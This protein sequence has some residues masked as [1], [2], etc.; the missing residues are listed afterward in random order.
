MLCF[1]LKRYSESQ[2]FTTPK[3]SPRLKSLSASTSI[4]KKFV[5]SLASRMLKSVK[6]NHICQKQIRLINK[7]PEF[8]EVAKIVK[9]FKNPKNPKSFPHSSLPTP[10]TSIPSSL[11]QKR[12]STELLKITHTHSLSSTHSPSSTQ[13]KIPLPTLRRPFQKPSRFKSLKP[14]NAYLKPQ[15]FTHSQIF[16]K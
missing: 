16:F 1:R 4:K 7:H 14:S 15:S 10:V 3:V 11:T 5:S 6:H 9:N 8:K 2:R 13:S 12:I